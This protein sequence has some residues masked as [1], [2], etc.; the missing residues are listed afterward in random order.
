MRRKNTLVT[1]HVSLCFRVVALCHSTH[2][3][4]RMERS[5]CST[6]W[7]WIAPEPQQDCRTSPP[8]SASATATGQFTHSRPGVN[9]GRL[10]NLRLMSQ[11]AHSWATQV[12]VDDLSK[13][14]DKTTH[15]RNSHQRCGTGPCLG[16]DGAS[17]CVQERIS[18]ISGQVETPPPC[19]S[20]CPER[21]D[22][23]WPKL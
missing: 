5:G 1:K 13:W 16:K 6:L 3:L 12:E 9:C 7:I 11:Q 22:K 18:E 15:S 20:Q 21:S 4:L 17:P 14:L 2:L 19:S 8:P 23:L 10:V